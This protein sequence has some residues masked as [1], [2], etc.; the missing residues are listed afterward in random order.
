MAVIEGSFGGPDEITRHQA[1]LLRR[2]G[3]RRSSMPRKRSSRS[4]AAAPI[5]RPMGADGGGGDARLAQHRQKEDKEMKQL[6]LAVNARLAECV[7]QVQEKQEEKQKLELKQ[8]TQLQCAHINTTRDRPACS[9]S[10]ACLMNVNVWRST[11]RACT[12]RRLRPSMPG[13]GR[14]PPRQGPRGTRQRAMARRRGCP[15]RA[16]LCF[17]RSR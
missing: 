1:S 5:S 4:N 6:R 11:W 13:C 7:R 2:R 3:S 15:P 10:A 17:P 16:R 14:R 9:C 12:E 8:K